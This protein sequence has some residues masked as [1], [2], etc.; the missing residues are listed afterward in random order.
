MGEVKHQNGRHP[1]IGKEA[2]MA[3]YID[4]SAIAFFFWTGKSYQ[5]GN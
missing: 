4:I 3:L 5:S 2:A 1:G